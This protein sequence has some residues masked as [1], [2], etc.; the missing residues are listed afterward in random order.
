MALILNIDTATQIASIAIASDGKVLAMA[1]NQSMMDHA[2]WIHEAIRD[3]MGG[4]EL[5]LSQLDAIAVTGGPGSYTGIRV[6]MATAKGL[7]YVLNCSMIMENTLTVMAVAAHDSPL[8]N[9]NPLLLLCPMIDARRMEVFTAVYDKDLNLLL[10]PGNMILEPESFRQIMPGVPKLFFGSGAV[11]FSKICNDPGVIFGKITYDA[12]NL[13][14]ISERKFLQKDFANI[15]YSEPMY[16][17]EFYTPPR[18]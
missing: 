2:G 12:S 15:A 11:K 6:G 9:K 3:V 7:C 1:T 5:S 17:K 4:C 13:A 14:V 10:P 8:F 18:K 16:L